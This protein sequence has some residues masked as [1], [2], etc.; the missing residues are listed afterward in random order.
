MPV[1]EY[2]GQHYELSTTDPAAAK[3]KILSYLGQQAAPADATQ[4]APAAAAQAA[5]VAATEPP[6]SGLSGEFAGFA[7]VFAQPAAAEPVAAAPK[8]TQPKPYTNRQEALNDAVNM[9]EEGFDQNQVIQSFKGIG[10]NWNEIIKRGKERSSPYFR[11]QYVTPEE[12]ARARAT[13]RTDT[14]TITGREPGALEGTANH[15]SGYP[16]WR[17]GNRLPVLYRS[18]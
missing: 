16:L 13:P 5:P 2:K 12:A 14:G 7:D 10:V 8:Q 18:F 4:T 6:P 11:E 17:Y 1:Y 9:L 15:A 3:A